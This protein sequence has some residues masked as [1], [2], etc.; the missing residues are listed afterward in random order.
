V[1]SALDVALG[2]SARR[3]VSAAPTSNVAA[4][5][6][7]LKGEAASQGLS[8]ADPASLRRAIS[9]YEQAVALDSSFVRA[10]A[11]LS[12][13][14]AFLYRNSVPTPELQEGA[15]AAAARVRTLAPASPEAALAWG[16]FEGRVEH[17]NQSAF[18]ALQSGLKA[19]PNDVE[20]LTEAALTEQDLG[21]WEGASQHF[22]RALA[23][24]PR[25]VVGARRLTETLLYLR[26]YPAAQAAADRAL[27]L[28]PTN[29]RLVELQAMLR[30]AQGD[31]T[32]A[33]AVI[34]S[35][36]TGIDRGTLYA[37]FGLYQDLYWVL[38]DS[39]QLQLLALPVTAFDSDRAAWSIVR[40]QT[41]FLRGDQTRSR[42]YADSAR[43]AF[44]EQ[45]RAAPN[46]GQRHVI[47]GLALAYMGQKSEAIRE[48]ERGT[49]LV[50]LSMDARSG[51]YMQHQ[52]AR[53]YALTG[54]PDKAISILE[55]LLKIP[56]YLSP[57]WLR[58]DPEFAM[59]KG[60]PRFDRLTAQ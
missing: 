12:I 7:Y 8:V 27:A 56:Y 37:F 22:A 18:D 6:A 14:R 29:L 55:S 23:L 5:D 48:G 54:E 9:F 59:L 50:P 38:D 19:A 36:P 11:H 15:R 58:I 34:V 17:D 39:Q 60:N 53:I 25:S 24:D 52:L 44:E 35:A 2:D 46:D 3:T 42:I 28:A 13:E 40:A 4:Y 49:Q 10:W 32:G 43:V 41:Y 26:R 45:I 51:A 30:L 21:R 20:L 31:L 47:V 57:G 16:T 1:A 33:H